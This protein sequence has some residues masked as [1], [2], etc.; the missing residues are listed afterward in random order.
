[1]SE[2]RELQS[3]AVAEYNRPSAQQT[4]ITCD[5]ITPAA[6]AAAAGQFT[7]QSASAFYEALYTR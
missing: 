6:A 5:V 3:A 1:M 4:R 7:L 2:S